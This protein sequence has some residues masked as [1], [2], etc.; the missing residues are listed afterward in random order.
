MTRPKISIIRQS[1]NYVIESVTLKNARS[2]IFKTVLD[3]AW[4]KAARWS[5]VFEL[6]SGTAGEFYFVTVERV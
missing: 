2:K 5:R 4:Q 3:D 6:T 1:D